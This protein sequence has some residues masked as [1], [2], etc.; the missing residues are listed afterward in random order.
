MSQDRLVLLKNKQTGETIR[1]T[2]NK[3]G[4]E[5]KLKFKKYS[6]KLRK[7]VE[8]TEAKK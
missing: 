3:K 5:R 7:R 4:V 6:P 2:K 1:T 8:F